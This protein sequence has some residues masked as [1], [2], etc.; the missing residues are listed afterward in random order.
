V[1]AFLAGRLNFASIPAVIEAVMTSMPRGDATTL[2]GVLA[3]DQEARQRA[4]QLASSEAGVA[5]R[6]G[7]GRTEAA[8]APAKG[9]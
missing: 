2:E 8:A 9:H 1:G 4:A 5:I 6:G 7:S 3:A